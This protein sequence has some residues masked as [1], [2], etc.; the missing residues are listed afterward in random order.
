[1]KFAQL[2]LRS[3][4]RISAPALLAR[5]PVTAKVVLTT[6]GLGFA[7]WLSTNKYFSEE[8]TLLETEDNLL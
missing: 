8:M 3:M 7:T 4:T 6:L 2:F 5:K 1:M